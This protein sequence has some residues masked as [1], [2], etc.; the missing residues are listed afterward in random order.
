MSVTDRFSTLKLLLGKGIF[1][2]DNF[3]WKNKKKLYLKNDK[4]A[5]KIESHQSPIVRSQPGFALKISKT[6]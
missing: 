2:L 4:K 5:K 6:Y 1:Y 3:L